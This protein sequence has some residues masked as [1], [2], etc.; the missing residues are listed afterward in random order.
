MK[1]ENTGPFFTWKLS[2]FCEYINVPITSAGNRSGVNCMRLNS[3]LT[4]C[5]RVL[6][7]RVFAN[8]GTPSSN[9]CPSLSR[10][11]SRL[12]TKCFCPTMTP[13]MP[14]LMLVIKALCC[15]IRMFSSLMSITSA[16]IFV[17]YFVKIN[18]PNLFIPQK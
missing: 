7:A 17:V 10:P 5:A 16:M 18:V 13:S 14:R 11:I 6:M 1:F 4:S 2:V 9:I 3:V 8:P 15:S 12:S